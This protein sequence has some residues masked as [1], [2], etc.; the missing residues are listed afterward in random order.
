MFIGFIDGDGS[1]GKTRIK[2][3]NHSSWLNILNYYLELLPNT[4]PTF[5]DKRGYAYL[6]LQ[7]EHKQLLLQHIN[8]F[9][10]PVMKRKWN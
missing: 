6:S 3:V 5:I 4:K 1:V 7:K 8:N 9:N 10:L 2:I